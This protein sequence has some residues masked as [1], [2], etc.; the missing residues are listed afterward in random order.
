MC[1]G[2][3]DVAHAAS[4]GSLQCSVLSQAEDVCKHV[5][6]SMQGNHL[7]VSKMSI[8]D[9][10]QSFNTNDF[11]LSFFFPSEKFQG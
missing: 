4:P 10:L 9:I 5:S 2:A 8:K 11:S 7:D 6:K 3:S 1:V